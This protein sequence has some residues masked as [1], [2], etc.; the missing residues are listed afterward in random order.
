MQ[1][2]STNVTAVMV[3]G[4]VFGIFRSVCEVSDAT[5]PDYKVFSFRDSAPWKESTGTL[6]GIATTNH[7]TDLKYDEMDEYKTLE[8]YRIVKKLETPPGFI[9][10][11][12]VT[13]KPK[14]VVV[15]PEPKFDEQGARCED[16]IATI[17][18]ADRRMTLRALT[19]KASAHRYSK[20]LWERSLQTLVD[21]GEIRLEA[22]VTSPKR[23]WVI[24]CS[25]P[26]SADCQ[27][28]VSKD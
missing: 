16:A 10:V 9:A 19:R 24:Y 4:P 14:P 26:L 6:R 18:E 12:E 7:P 20:D 3:S 1:M 27:Q 2:S 15:A 23:T 22:D 28:T 17:V 8:H 11:F 13:T 25:E 21:A 5:D